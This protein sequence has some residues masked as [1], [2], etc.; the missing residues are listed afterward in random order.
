MRHADRLSGQPAQLPRLVKCGEKKCR[1]AI[2]LEDTK[3][4]R[5]RAQ[6]AANG[7]D[8]SGVHS[9]ARQ[10]ARLTDATSPEKHRLDRLLRRLRNEQIVHHAS[11]DM[12]A[13]NA[14]SIAEE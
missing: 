9:V 13:R 8:L 5:G 4:E 12:D 14:R 7:H 1:I 3:F 6:G 10:A 11:N 2:G